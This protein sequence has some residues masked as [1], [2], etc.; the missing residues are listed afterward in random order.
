MIL[1]VLGSKI[2]YC[3][4]IEFFFSKKKD[5]GLKTDLAL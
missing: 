3:L 5:Q 4:F 1:V 2:W